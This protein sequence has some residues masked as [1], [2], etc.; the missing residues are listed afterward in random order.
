MQ[1]SL[2]PTRMM[3]VSS[4]PQVSMFFAVSSF[5]SIKE[6]KFDGLNK[7]D[8]KHLKLSKEPSF[9]FRFSI[10]K[11][12]IKAFDSDT[13][14][15]LSALPFLNSRQQQELR[16]QAVMDYFIQGFVHDLIKKWIPARN[17][18]NMAIEGIRYDILHILLHDIL[19]IMNFRRPVGFGSGGKT[20]ENYI[21]DSD[22]KL[23][24]NT[25][26]THVRIHLRK[27]ISS[28]D[29]MKEMIESEIS[30]LF[31]NFHIIDK[32]SFSIGFRKYDCKGLYSASTL[33]EYEEDDEH[34]KADGDYEPF[35]DY[36]VF[37]PSGGVD[38]KTLSE[39]DSKSDDFSWIAEG[40]HPMPM[41]INPE[42]DEYESEEMLILHAKIANECPSFKMCLHP[43]DLL[44]GVF[45]NPVSNSDRMVAQQGS[46]MLFGLSNF[47]NVGRAIRYFAVN[48]HEKYEDILKYLIFN[49]DS[50]L[51]TKNDDGYQTKGIIPFVEFVFGAETYEINWINR[52]K[53]KE[54]LE[55]IGIN[56]ATM[57]RSPETTVYEI[58]DR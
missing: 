36:I 19:S 8:K 1:H 24:E 26:K 42:T 47:W 2:I 52:S 58:D 13:C 11:N 38:A 43:I 54:Q 53:I 10:A 45:V 29:E 12:E 34:D 27:Y 14:R 57:G 5:N 20:Y 16:F 15:A 3:D 48:L 18:H 35:P 21:S 32:K 51:G 37:Y 4:N 40:Y 56:K 6:D 17:D 31:E 30:F 55:F 39:Y 23:I 33:K 50:F 28:S 46:F 41:Y 22:R 9:F 44:N 7:D 25:V 49:D